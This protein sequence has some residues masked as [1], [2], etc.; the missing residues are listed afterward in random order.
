VLDA[1]VVVLASGGSVVIG[2]L[3]DD[4]SRAGGG[5]TVLV[6]GDVGDGVDQAA[7]FLSRP[8]CFSIAAMRSRA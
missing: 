7:I 8:R 6:G 2:W 5:E 1:V 3:D 4:G